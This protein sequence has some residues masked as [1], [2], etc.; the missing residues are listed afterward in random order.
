MR[1]KN[2]GLKPAFRCGTLKYIHCSIAMSAEHMSICSP[3]HAN[4]DVAIWVDNFQKILPNGIKTTTN[5]DNKIK[6][7][8]VMNLCKKTA[9]SFVNE[10]ENVDVIECQQLKAALWEHA[11]KLIVNFLSGTFFL[12]EKDRNLKQHLI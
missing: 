9:P 4:S 1:E 10:K 7:N 3:S 6:H 2:Q 8:A 5:F 11:T 12:C